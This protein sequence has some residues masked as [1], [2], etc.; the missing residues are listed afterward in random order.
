[1]TAPPARVVRDVPGRL[2][3]DRERERLLDRHVEKAEGGDTDPLVRAD[4][5][6]R[7][8]DRDAECECRRDEDASS[9]LSS[10]PSDRPTRHHG[11]RDKSPGADAQSQPRRCMST[12][13]RL[14]EHLD[15][16]VQDPDD[17][18][19]WC[20]RLALLRLR[21]HARERRGRRRYHDERSAAPTASRTS[22]AALATTLKADREEDGERDDVA[23]AVER[24]R[25]RSAPSRHRRVAAQPAGAEDLTDAHR[26]H[27]VTRETAEQHPV[28]RPQP[29]GGVS[30]S[31]A[32]APPGTRSRRRARGP[33][34]GRPVRASH[35]RA[36]RGR[37]SE[38]GV[39]ER[40]PEEERTRGEAD[41]RDEHLAVTSCR[42][43]RTLL[44]HA[45]SSCRSSQ[46]ARAQTSSSSP[47][48]AS[49]RSSG[50]GS[51][52]GRC[53]TSRRF[54]PDASNASTASSSER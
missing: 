7:R 9:G 34:A 40:E 12:A 13:D 41:E 45:R 28:E 10:I 39:A 2:H 15:G 31:A 50:V 29:E 24:R 1:M 49:S 4:V 37:A 6:R 54:A 51:S 38:V 46:R 32:S 8:G 43:A 20:V 36:R 21:V 19:A 11:E 23:D 42:H 3:E 27:V 14:A 18:S 26:E 5:A 22:Q 52:R 53:V 17:T 44:R 16:V 33:P 47:S 35:R 48:Y 25:F 30:R